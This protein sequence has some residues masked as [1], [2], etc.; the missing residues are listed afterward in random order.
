VLGIAVS[1][2]L[3]YTV[4]IPPS[5]SAEYTKSAQYT[6][7][8]NSCG[9]TQGDETQAAYPSSDYDNLVDNTATLLRKY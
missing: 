7:S 9:N 8:A 4:G 5:I 1:A 2:I 3:A 6:S